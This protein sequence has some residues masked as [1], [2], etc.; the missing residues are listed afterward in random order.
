[1]K[2]P[3]RKNE[4]GL[5]LIEV[6]IALAILGIALTA[7]IQSASQNI[8]NTI[9]LQNRTIAVWVG[10]YVINSIRIGVIKLS[11]TPDILSK[12]NQTLGQ[13]FVWEAALDA[14]PNP[15]IKKIRVDVYHLPGHNKSAHLESYVDI[16]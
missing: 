8:K 12:E 5:T 1:M 11:G 7:I 3:A 2:K 10:T 16:P 4:S 6:L 15:R 14:T 13:N 9:Y